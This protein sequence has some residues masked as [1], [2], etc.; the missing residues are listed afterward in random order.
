MMWL[1]SSVDSVEVRMV[2]SMYA[3]Y[4]REQHGLLV[5][6]EQLALDE[7]NKLGKPRFGMLWNCI[8]I[9]MYIYIYIY[10]Y[11]Y[12][13]IY[14]Y[15]YMRTYTYDTLYIYIH[16]HAHM[17]TYIY[18]C[19]HIHIHIYIYIYLYIYIHIHIYTCM[20][21]VYVQT[22]ISSPRTWQSISIGNH[23]IVTRIWVLKRVLLYHYHLLGICLSGGTLTQDFHD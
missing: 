20:Y 17:Y 7:S 13:Y 14:M 5:T 15:I 16:T 19:I 9:H 22:H 11:M 23:M 6:G 8:C 10:I 18:I 2:S 12:V 21:S 1:R 4:Y 3:F